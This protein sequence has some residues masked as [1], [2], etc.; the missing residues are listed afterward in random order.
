M[1]DLEKCAHPMC[2]CKVSKDGQ[3]GKFC[4]VHCQ[5]AKSETEIKCDCKHPACR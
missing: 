4:S 3:Y 2:K 5:E 1:S